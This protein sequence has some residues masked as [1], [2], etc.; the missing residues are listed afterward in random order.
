MRRNRYD[1]AAA[2]CASS[3]TATVVWSTRSLHPMANLLTATGSSDF[4]RAKSATRA[5]FMPSANERNPRR[6]AASRFF[7]TL[8]GRLDVFRP[9]REGCHV[10]H[11][12]A[13]LAGPLIEQGRVNS[14]RFVALALAKAAC[15]GWLALAPCF[16]GVWPAAQVSAR[17]RPPAGRVE[18]RLSRTR[19][20]ETIMTPHSPGNLP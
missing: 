6:G 19:D 9:D 7:E 16:D 4:M 13:P 15:H 20:A 17:W 12:F 3:T 2:I 11:G 8:Y 1:S 5:H 10:L 14:W 18:P